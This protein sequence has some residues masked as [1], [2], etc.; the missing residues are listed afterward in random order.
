MSYTFR[1]IF[2]GICGFV[3]NTPFFVEKNGK[4]EEGGSVDK[5][6]VLLPN[7]QN[8]LA[9]PWK[10]NR[11]R[12]VREPHWAVITVEA[13]KVKTTGNPRP[14]NLKWYGTIKVRINGVL[15]EKKDTEWA[16]FLL[17]REKVRFVPADLVPLSVE[18]KIPE[19][20]DTPNEEPGGDSQSLWWLPQLAVISPRDREA[21][22]KFQPSGR[23]QE[24]LSGVVEIKSGAL[25]VVDFNRDDLGQPQTWNF[26]HPTHWWNLAKRWKR[27]IGNVLAL[28]FEGQTK[29]LKIELV[30]GQ[31]LS[32][33]VEGDAKDPVQIFVSNMEADD[34]LLGT[35]FKRDRV[36]DPDFLEFYRLS[37]SGSGVGPVP[38]KKASSA[39]PKIDPC[40]PGAYNGWKS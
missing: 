28:T 8:S 38:N 6:D 4:W 39:G 25:A 7:C 10:D 23:V 29:P 9:A 1:V 17:D 31:D 15:V 35:P 18:R 20:P 12:V 16:S 11:V 19:K 37:S 32:F 40:S 13:S 22:K 21:N 5:I 26:K 34:R 36:R 3:P 14:F 30:S 24:D 27:P 33:E 2:E